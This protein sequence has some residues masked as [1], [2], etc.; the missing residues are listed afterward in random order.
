MADEPRARL[1]ARVLVALRWPVLLGWCVAAGAAALLL[2]ALGTSGGGLGDVTTTDN[3]ALLAEARAAKDLG[4][5]LLSRLAVV[6]HDPAGLPDAARQ[7]AV[8]AARALAE[9][10]TEH[11]RAAVPV[12][13]DERLPAVR[14]PGTTV[15][16][17]LYPQPG[18]SFAGAL[19]GAHA[20]AQALG[21]QAG[22]VGVTGSL[23][24]RAAQTRVIEES[25]RLLEAGSLAA[26]LLVVGVAFR[27]VVAPLLTLG[28]SG[29]SFVLVTRTAGLLG[30]RFGWDVPADLEP[31]MV[32]LML[33]IVTDYVVYF[34]S[35]LRA[36][37]ADGHP[38]VD[39]A[40]R[41]TGVFAP[42]VL[43]AGVTVSA[44]V[45]ALR[46]ADSPPVR[47][48]GPAMAVTVLVTLLVCVTLV[49]ALMAVLG[50]WCVWP[51]RPESARRESVAALLRRGTVRVIR[52]RAGAAVVAV[53][54]LAGLGALTLPVLGLRAGLP[55]VASLPADDEVRRAADAAASGFAAGITS[56]TL[57][58]VAASDAGAQ[59]EPLDAAA[60]GRLQ[61]LVARQPHV[62]GV[63]GPREETALAAAAGRETGLF[64]RADRLAAQYLVVLDVDP[65]DADAVR[66]VDR[67][68][69]RLP[70]LLREAGLPAGARAGVG[71]D[72]A[73]VAAVVGQ[74]DR[75]LLVIVLAAL[76]VNLALMA[77]FLRALVAPVLLLVCTVLSAGATLGLTTL[78][79]QGELG[80]PGVTFFVPLAAGVLLLALGSDYNLFAVGHVWA[81]ARHRPLREAMLAALP[82]SSAAITTAGV[83]LAASLGTLALVPLRQFRELAFAL[84][85][86]ILLDALVVRTL[87]APS[88]LTLFG[89]VSGWPGRRLDVAE[90]ARDEAA[91]REWAARAAARAP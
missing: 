58:E 41:T 15:V 33:G 37:L 30:E 82:Q 75:D 78:V 24:A 53:V 79:F 73:A 63:I 91:R 62:A 3:P 72:S 28:V 23:P 66:A 54:C 46:L 70:G 86:G 47:A 81:H 10:P 1:W 61:D 34:L 20:Y 11:L 16:T 48:F 51:S 88:L 39:A 89:R 19:E 50:R 22:V 18:T 13:S 32:A 85:V 55:F 56:P 43:V 12:P 64:V 42:I 35:G 68:T 67:L 60:L 59:G 9:R 45:M 87:L 29:L 80:H 71:G 74:S 40:A 44:G 31:L 7:A 21:P 76:A 2:P 17:F 52:T 27:S 83:A 57:V 25:L 4:V 5:P 90:E 49:P 38:R 14:T 77:L 26:V 84:V 69:E 65:L 36:D 8:D 6:Q